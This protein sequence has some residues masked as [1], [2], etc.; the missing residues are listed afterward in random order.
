MKK[1]KF[2]NPAKRDWVLIDVKGKVLGRIATQIAKILRGKNK[3]CFT[4]SSLCGDNVVV[5]NAKYIRVTGNKIKDKVYDRY[6]GYHGGR[7]E[8]TFERLIKKNPALILRMAVYGMVPK[9][10]LGKRMMRCLKIYP[11]ETHEHSAQKPKR[12]EV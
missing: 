4:P 12:I 7:K 9:N 1:T 11:E 3:A 5:V 6:S 10:N 2:F 8:I